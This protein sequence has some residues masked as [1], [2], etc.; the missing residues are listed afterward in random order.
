MTEYELHQLEKILNVCK[1]FTP[2]KFNELSALAYHV[3]YMEYE[4]KALDAAFQR[5][6]RLKRSGDKAKA[7][8]RV[9]D[10]V[11][12]LRTVAESAIFCK[13]SKQ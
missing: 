1:D 10:Q 7:W 11:F 3:S 12:R 6:S 2:D 13:S 5:Y 8:D 9:T 4:R